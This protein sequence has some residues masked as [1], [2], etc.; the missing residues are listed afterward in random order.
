VGC[1]LGLSIDVIE[2]DRVDT[3]VETMVEFE[4]EAIDEQ[5][6]VKV[7]SKDGISVGRMLL[8]GVVFKLRLTDEIELVETEGNIVDSVVCTVEEFR[9]DD[10]VDKAMLDSRV[11]GKLEVMFKSVDGVI[12]EYSL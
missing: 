12:V 3:S 2:G 4:E 5:L 8:N 11:D 9:T 7:G 6:G 10:G 1:S